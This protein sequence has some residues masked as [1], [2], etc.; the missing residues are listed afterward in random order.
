MTIELKPELV[1]LIKKRLDSG[2]FQNVE[3][4][5]WQALR[6]Q[7][8]ELSTTADARLHRYPWGSDRCEI[9]L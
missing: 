8:A 9:W 3:D 2:V 5:L 6:S 4:V 1:A 7:D